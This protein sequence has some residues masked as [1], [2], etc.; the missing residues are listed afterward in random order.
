MAMASEEKIDAS[1]YL[2]SGEEEEEED[3]SDYQTPVLCGDCESHKDVNSYCLSCNIDICDK[4]KTRKLHRPHKILPR[5]HSEVVRARK[6]VRHPCK[7]HPEQEY[8]IFCKGCQ[9]PCCPD[10]MLGKHNQHFFIEIEEAADEARRSLPAILASLEETTLPAEEYAYTSAANYVGKYKDSILTTKEESKQRFQDLRETINLMES[11]SRKNIDMRREDDLKEI[12]QTKTCIKEQMTSTKELI[13]KCKSNLETASNIV[14]LS[15]H[16]ECQ[17]AGSF[18]VKETVLPPLVCFIPSQYQL[19]TPDE[20][21]GSI[22]KSSRELQ[23]TTMTTDTSFDP[24]MIHVVLLKTI[25]L[26]AIALTANDRG[27][28]W[29]YLKKTITIYNKKYHSE[30]TIQ[31]QQT[32]EDFAAVTAEEVIA[33]TQFCFS[34]ALVKISRSG[35][36]TTIC[37]TGMMEPLG[38]GINHRQE[39]MVIFG[40]NLS[41]KKLVIY[42][43]DGS[44][45]LKDIQK[46][47]KGKLLFDIYCKFTQVKQNSNEDYVLSGNNSIVCVSRDGKLRW[48]HK[49][50]GRVY[51]LVCDWYANIVVAEYDNNQITLLDSEGKKITTLLTNKDGICLPRSLALDTQGNLWVGQENNVKIFKYIR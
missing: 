20:L 46:N 22:S 3:V 35:K 8:I 7:E 9:V 13:E 38:I 37:S 16:S 36:F 11:E 14:V 21:I 41:H 27:E 6:T 39:I 31:I 44:I 15:Y 26:G 1:D 40:S 51:G 10:C 42:S 32:I 4:C 17:K 25:P 29:S 49:E 30:K 47:E 5:T 45:V 28:V 19:P 12:Q 48:E 23:K 33:T 50:V 2:P 43:P 34:N 18:E 24:N